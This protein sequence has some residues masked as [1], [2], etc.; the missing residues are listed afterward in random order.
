MLI[1]RD[2]I[3]I[4]IVF[5][6]LET[7]KEKIPIESKKVL[8]SIVSQV[9]S[10]VTMILQFAVAIMVIWA[11]VDTVVKGGNYKS[12]VETVWSKI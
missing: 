1:F 11:V 10:A 4:V 12:I 8:I 9:I 2:L 5:I 3:V 6:I 7:I